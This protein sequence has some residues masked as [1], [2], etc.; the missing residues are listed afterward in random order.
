MHTPVVE[1]PELQQ[2]E[3]LA[4][5]LCAVPFDERFLEASWTWLNDEEI[6]Q[7]TMTPTFTKPQQ[8]AWFAKLGERKDYLI[9]GIELDGKPIGAFGIKNLDSRSGEYWGYLGDKNCWGQGIG[10]WMV[11]EA[12]RRARDLGI[13]RLW[14]RVSQENIRAIKLYMSCGFR[15]REGQGAVTLMEREV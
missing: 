7:L 1:E 8:L 3:M 6:R 15:V 11:S 13:Q 14:L 12:I 2:V 9:W 5:S 4:S 10:K